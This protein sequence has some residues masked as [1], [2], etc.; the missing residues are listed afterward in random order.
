MPAW[1]DA[2][3]EPVLAIV[4]GVLTA[5]AV[6]LMLSRHLVRFL[7]GLMLLSNGVNIV[8]FASG[9]L[10]LVEP[11]LIPGDAV[12]PAGDVANALPQALILTAIVIGFGLLS[13]VMVLVWRAYVS[14]GTVDTDAMREAEPVAEAAGD[15][16]TPGDG[17]AAPLPA[18]ATVHGS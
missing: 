8:I 9:R 12:V 3:M 11:P 5:A 18:G 17:T 16:A 13:F 10:T 14:L 1:T 7:F 6:Y 15:A 4:A 2:G